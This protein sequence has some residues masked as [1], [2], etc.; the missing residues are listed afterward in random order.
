MIHNFQFMRFNF[1]FWILVW[2]DGAFCLLTLFLFNGP[3]HYRIVSPSCLAIIMVYT[4]YNTYSLCVV[5]RL[6]DQART[7]KE[8]QGCTFNERLNYLFKNQF[9]CQFQRVNFLCGMVSW[10]ERNKMR[11]L[12]SFLLLVSYTKQL[13]AT[14]QDLVERDLTAMG[15]LYSIA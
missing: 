4:I 9:H 13:K 1:P 8:D 12:T 10:Y 11:M 2:F 6:A 7:R 14:T 15:V 3:S 5:A